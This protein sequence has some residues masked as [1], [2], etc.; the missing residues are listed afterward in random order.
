MTDN[1][2]Y[3][4][5]PTPEFPEESPEEFIRRAIRGME[6]V[7]KQIHTVPHMRPQRSAS[8]QPMVQRR[9]HD[10]GRSGTPKTLGQLS[11]SWDGG[12]D[13]HN[14]KD[15][16]NEK[17]DVPHRTPSPDL[18]EWDVLQEECCLEGQV[19]TKVRRNSAV[20]ID[21]P[22]I[23]FSFSLL[24]NSQ[25]DRVAFSRATPPSCPVSPR[26]PTKDAGS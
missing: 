9:R 5:P 2:N 23:F 3:Q 10:Q 20:D 26:S 22:V 19:T 4:Y 12:A 7:M 21:V 16:P 6:S 11:L 18:A 17:D 25:I 15:E 24:F 13:E 8:E 14:D 1:F